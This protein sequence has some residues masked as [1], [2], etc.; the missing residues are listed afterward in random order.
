MTKHHNQEDDCRQRFVITVDL[1]SYLG[2]DLIAANALLNVLTCL[3]HDGIRPYRATL[4]ISDTTT[5]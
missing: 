4:K 3:E 5:H 1:P 2:T